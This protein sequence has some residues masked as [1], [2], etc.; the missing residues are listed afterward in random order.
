MKTFVA[1]K[2]KYDT[3]GI[4]VKQLGLPKEIELEVSDETDD[5]E[6]VELLSDEISDKTGYCHLGFSMHLK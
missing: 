2:I 3:D 4:P 1:T 5:E 6:A